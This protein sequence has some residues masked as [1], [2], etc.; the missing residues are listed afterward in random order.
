MKQ[1]YNN[2]ITKHK[3]LLAISIVLVTLCIVTS[4]CK[5]E[6]DNKINEMP[7]VLDPVLGI[8]DCGDNPYV[9]YGEQLFSNPNDIYEAKLYF[10]FIKA[11]QEP[12]RFKAHYVSDFIERLNEDYKVARIRFKE[13]GSDI[14][15][16]PEMEADIEAFYSL[17]QRVYSKKGY[18]NIFIY[19]STLGNYSGMAGGIPSRNM[20]IKEYYMQKKYNT[21][22]HE[23]AHCFGLR[24]THQY[25]DSN[26]KNSW[27]SGD[28]I[29]A[30]DAGSYT[31]NPSNMGYLGLV[32]RNCNYTGELGNMTQE[33]HNHLI[34]NFMS[35]SPCRSEFDEDQ[36]YRVHFIIN[37][38]QDIKECFIK[39]ES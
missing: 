21:G 25:D 4:S 26:E 3:V 6:E 8:S 31:K 32:D 33:E 27:D 11:E 17:H 37:N 34:K 16:V 7:V 35:Y 9:L 29:C 36:I 14:I 20:A 12:E 5:T 23:V 18:L 19:P 24:H 15:E 22:T 30:T 2:L 10:H 13:G 28:L 1:Q 38:A 39:V